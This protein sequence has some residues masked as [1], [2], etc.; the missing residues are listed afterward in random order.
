MATTPE[1]RLDWAHQH[2]Q[3]LQTA[4]AQYLASVHLSETDNVTATSVAGCV[5]QFE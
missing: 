3:R 4:A 1:Q 5:R 2:L